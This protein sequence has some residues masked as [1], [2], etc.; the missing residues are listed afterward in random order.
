MRKKFFAKIMLCGIMFALAFAALF[1]GCDPLEGSIESILEKVKAGQTGAGVI[2]VSGVSLNKNSLVITLGATPENSETLI[3]VVNPEDATNKNLSWSSDNAP[4]ATVDE[5]GKVT[6]FTVG[7]ATITVTTADGG[8]TDE[9]IVSVENASVT[10]VS[11]NKTALTLT[12]GQFETLTATISPPSAPNKNVSWASSN[13]DVATVDSNGKVTAIAIGI[14]KITVTTENSNK[15]A[16]CTVTVDP[17][18]VTIYNA[19]Y[20][21]TGGTN[22]QAVY[23]KN[24][25]RTT[26]PQDS[27]GTGSS[28]TAIYVSNNTV[29]TSG[30]NNYGI[31]S[32]RSCYWTSNI[33]TG[34][35]QTL[36]TYPT[37]ERRFSS[38]AIVR[39]SITV[40]TAG[41]YS[42]PSPSNAVHAVYWVDT[43]PVIL[44]EPSGATGS[45]AKAIAAD[46]AALYIAGQY[47]KSDSTIYQHGIYWS[48][49]NNQPVLLIEPPGTVNSYT[50]AIT[51]VNGTVYTA[52]YCFDNNLISSALYW[53]NSSPI[54]L[55]SPATGAAMIQLTAITAADNTVYTAGTYVDSTYTPYGVYWTDTTPTTLFFPSEVTFYEAEINKI[56]VVNGKVYVAGYYTSGGLKYPC[57]WKDGVRIAVGTGIDG[58][59]DDSFMVFE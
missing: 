33:G 25:V 1:T 14:A 49:S 39:S 21:S 3:A 53:K 38:R 12:T 23:W 59:I 20:I 29:Y 55:P 48:S 9:C 28:A 16:D 13:T 47:T 31:T 30:Y 58:E 4:V 50:T 6:G 26:L 35:T 7:A 10:G 22:Y 57:Y 40:C 54:V 42:E 15:T 51:A 34:S 46:G 17:S 24:G 18:S 36:Q 2:P 44:T 5:N 27:T 43:S 45:N 19:G 52:G 41:L 11:L 8:K 56:S 32:Y 37:S